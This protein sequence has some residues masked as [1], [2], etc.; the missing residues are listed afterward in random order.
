MTNQQWH[1]SEFG[2]FEG[3]IDHLRCHRMSDHLTSDPWE[4]FGHW[5]TTVKLC[6]LG[7]AKPAHLA[8]IKGSETFRWHTS[9]MVNSDI[10]VNLVHLKGFYD[11]FKSHPS[12]LY[13]LLGWWPLHQSDLWENFKWVT[14]TCWVTH[15]SDLCVKCGQVTFRLGELVDQKK[16]SWST[17]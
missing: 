12:D 7:P 14:V 13:L 16:C 1:F 17:N 4:N 10:S 8:Q 15:S 5:L 2:S 9:D 6:N 3:F 11:M